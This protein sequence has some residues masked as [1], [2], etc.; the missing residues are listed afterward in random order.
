MLGV[1]AIAQLYYSYKIL[2]ELKKMRKT[3]ALMGK[4]SIMAGR[5]LV[6]RVL[7]DES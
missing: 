3:Y 5:Q 4:A 1:F 2:I 7:N 6:N